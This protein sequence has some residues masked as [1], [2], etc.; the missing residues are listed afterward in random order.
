MRWTAVVQEICM[1]LYI[2]GV[3]WKYSSRAAARDRAL[4]RTFAV[5]R[6]QRL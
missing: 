2:G 4:Q 3:L 5:H 1:N 6:E